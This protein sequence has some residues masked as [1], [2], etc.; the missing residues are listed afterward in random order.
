MNKLQDSEKFKY[1]ENSFE[2]LSRDKRFH[3]WMPPSLSELTPNQI[4]LEL[5]HLGLETSF[6]ISVQYILS[7]SMD[8][9]DK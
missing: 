7:L 3:K 5:T 2:K 9:R 6:Y 1:V 4:L 8:K